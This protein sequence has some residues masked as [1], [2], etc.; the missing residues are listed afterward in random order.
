MKAKVRGEA[1]SA[2]RRRHKRFDA[3]C[4][5]LLLLPQYLSQWGMNKAARQVAR[6]L[7]Q[8]FD[9]ELKRHRQ[10]QEGRVFPALLARARDSD[11]NDLSWQIARATAQHR[12]LDHAW[13]NLRGNLA[14][15]GFCRPAKLSLDDAK[16]FV[17]LCR[18]HVASEDEY[19][20]AHP[21]TLPR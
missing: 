15:I 7:C 19:L 8:Y 4:T 14:A 3:C 1:G 20:F 21:L 2:R 18:N 13:S 10:E 5:Q 11:V 16:R 17:M 12:V 6:H 9:D